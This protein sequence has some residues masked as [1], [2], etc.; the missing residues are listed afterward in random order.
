[1]VGCNYN[2]YQALT[3]CSE[4]TYNKE[5][6][7]NTYTHTHTWFRLAFRGVFGDSSLVYLAYLLIKAKYFWRNIFNE[8][9]CQPPLLF[10]TCV[11]VRSAIVPATVVAGDPKRTNVKAVSTH[12]YLTIIR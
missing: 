10:L 7:L 6:H 1:M 9:A 2:N 5:L 11:Q 4:C 12:N 8:D 3:E